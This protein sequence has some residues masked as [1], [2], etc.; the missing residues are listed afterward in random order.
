[1]VLLRLRHASAFEEIMKT[2]KTA[3]PLVAPAPLVGER[4]M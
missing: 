2:Q 4:P 1:M 3:R